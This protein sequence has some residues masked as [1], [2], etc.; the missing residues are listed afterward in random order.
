MCRRKPAAAT[1]TG[2]YQETLLHKPVGSYVLLDLFYFIYRLFFSSF[3]FLLF[4]LEFL[5]P[6]GKRVIYA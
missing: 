6:L 4:F 1:A 5:E 3:S 2:D